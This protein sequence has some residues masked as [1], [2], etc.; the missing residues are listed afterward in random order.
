MEQN[1]RTLRYKEAKQAYSENMELAAYTGVQLFFDILI[2]QLN[3]EAATQEK[4]N[5]DTL[6]GISK[7]R[8]EVGRIAETELLQIELS[9]ANAEN[10]IAQSTLNLQSSMEQLRTFLG[11]QRAA[12]FEMV[13]PLELPS[14]IVDPNQALQFALQNRSLIVSLERRLKEAERNIA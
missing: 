13:P 4:I 5:A 8:F 6:Y 10:A 12:R 1:H 3:V 11:I 14:F 7:G 9:V 2:A